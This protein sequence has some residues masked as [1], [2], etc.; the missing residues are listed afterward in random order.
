M[1]GN[2]KSRKF[3]VKKAM[4]QYR[5]EAHNSAISNTMFYFLTDSILVPNA[6]NI[7]PDKQYVH[8][9][10]SSQERFLLTKQ[11]TRYRVNGYYAICVTHIAF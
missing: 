11:E 3:S 8:P 5:K 10:L 1:H 2:V 7:F 9:F 4:R 6:P